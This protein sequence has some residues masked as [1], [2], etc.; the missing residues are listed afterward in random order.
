MVVGRLPSLSIC[1]TTLKRLAPHNPHVSLSFD[2]RNFETEVSFRLTQYIPLTIFYF[3]SLESRHRCKPHRPN[4]NPP[5]QQRHQNWTINPHLHHRIIMK[6]LSI[7]TLLPYVS[8]FSVQRMSNL[9]SR[10]ASPYYLVASC[11]AN[12]QLIDIM[13]TMSTS[14]T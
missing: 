9:A 7:I 13:A 12:N 2:F 6:Y 10:S 5:S 8:C 11:S 1:I 4:H 3:L 14:N